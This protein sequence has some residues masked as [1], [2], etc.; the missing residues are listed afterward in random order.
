M[1]EAPQSPGSFMDFIITHPEMG[2]T[3][4]ATS[5]FESTGRY[6]DALADYHG[7]SLQE[8]H[9]MSFRAGRL[10]VESIVNLAQETTDSI[11]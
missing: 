5:Y 8:L 4:A 9:E 3:E 1:P 6:R 2:E 10:S 7:V 11:A